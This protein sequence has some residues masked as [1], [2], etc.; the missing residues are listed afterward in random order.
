MR[1][2][3]DARLT[4]SV[5]PVCLPLDAREVEAELD[6]Q[7]LDRLDQSSGRALILGWGRTRFD[8]DGEVRVRFFIL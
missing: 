4:E 1:L 8:S 2:T 3:R 7:D 5:Q 6:L